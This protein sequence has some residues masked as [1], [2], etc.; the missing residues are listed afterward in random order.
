MI[1]IPSHMVHDPK[2]VVFA[3]SGQYPKVKVRKMYSDR[4]DMHKTE[5][6]YSTLLDAMKAYPGTHLLVLPASFWKSSGWSE[7]I[8]LLV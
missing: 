1:G 5:T 7:C 2:A 8:W 3:I 6:E 4:P